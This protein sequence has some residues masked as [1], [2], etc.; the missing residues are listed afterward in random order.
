MRTED[1]FLNAWE[2][3]AHFLNNHNKP[4]WLVAVGDDYHLTVIKP[5]KETIQR[6]TAAIQYEMIN[7]DIVETQRIVNFEGL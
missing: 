1:K 7:G 4:I 5:T 2:K 6:G 3:L